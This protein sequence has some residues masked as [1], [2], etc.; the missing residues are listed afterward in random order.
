MPAKVSGSP[1]TLA[2]KRS[3]QGFFEDGLEVKKIAMHLGRSVQAVKKFIDTDLVNYA[4]LVEESKDKI[5][6]E[7]EEA[8]FNQLVKSGLTE[9]DAKASINKVRLQLKKTITEND[10]DAL[11]RAALRN[12]TTATTFVR[13]TP[14]GRDG[15]AIASAA[16]SMHGDLIRDKGKTTSRT[17]R[18]AIYQHKDGKIV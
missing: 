18:G 16:S 10:V 7:V 13:K 8:A 6:P 12:T 2:E 11:V 5:P 1:L 14:G 9:I 17:A 4:Q 3:I 15:I